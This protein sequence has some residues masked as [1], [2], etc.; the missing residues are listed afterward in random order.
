MALVVD[1]SVAVK[2]LVPEAD[3][4]IAD[5]LLV[6]VE[7]LH[8]P[9]L[10]VSEVANALWRRSRLGDIEADH[11]S[12]LMDLIPE[13]PLRWRR[14]EELGGDALTLALDLDRP[15]HDCVYLAL[16]YRIGARVVT[17]DRRF[18]RAVA[19]T[20]YAAGVVTLEDHDDELRL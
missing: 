9:R 20:A 7:P 17:A 6:G 8:A 13:M 16:A 14:D 15:V 10:L 12:V 11:A 4:E 3:S 18:A 1:A 2:W 19:G 5:R